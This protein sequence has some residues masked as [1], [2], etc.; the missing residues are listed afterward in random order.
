MAGPGTIATAAAAV[1]LLASITSAQ[2]EPKRS[3]ESGAQAL[4]AARASYEKAR[5]HFEKRDLEK[6]VNE[7]EA[8]L[9]RAPEFSEAHFLYAKV[10]YLQKRFPEALERMTRAESSFEAGRDAYLAAQTDQ[11]REVERLRDRQATIIVELRS[12]LATATTE[13]QRRAIQE[14]VDE[15]ERGKTEYDR[16]LAE[17]PAP[18]AG[19]PADY[20]FFHGNILL[21]LNRLDEAVSRYRQALEANPAHAD[22]SN[23]LASIL[24][25][26][27]R[28]KAALEVLEKAEAAGA[29]V[30]PELKQAVLAAARN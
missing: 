10:E 1:S 14:A 7:L 21:R 15:A 12:Q 5:K 27:S 8:S 20:H 18:L 22:A 13:E 19:I 24:L 30:N 17:P 2:I 9:K 16:L 28:P 3:S 6:T 25:G 23:N 11:R 29:T 4:K 26:A